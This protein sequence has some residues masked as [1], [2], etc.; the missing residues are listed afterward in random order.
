MNNLRV[1]FGQIDKPHIG[2][3]TE[4]EYKNWQNTHTSAANPCCISCIAIKEKGWKKQVLWFPVILKRL[5][6]RQRGFV[7]RDQAGRDGKKKTNQK[8]FLQ[9]F[10]LVL[11]FFLSLFCL[12]FLSHQDSLT[13]YLSSV[14]VSASAD[15]APAIC[16]CYFRQQISKLLDEHKP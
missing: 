2:L 13:H 7:E 5:A 15:I 16:D 3:Y 1:Y 8:T 10:S 12:F 6:E 9:P 4:N 11:C 14:S